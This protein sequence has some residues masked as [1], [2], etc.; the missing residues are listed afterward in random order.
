MDRYQR[1]IEADAFNDEHHEHDMDHKMAHQL[2]PA[3]QHGRGDENQGEYKSQQTV[4][5]ADNKQIANYKF[6]K[7][8]H[9]KKRPGSN[10]KMR[11]PAITR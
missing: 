7:T 4:Q 9:D 8:S 11:T 2:H 5:N 6:D 1:F 3:E 10:P